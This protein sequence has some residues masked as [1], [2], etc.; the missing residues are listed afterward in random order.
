MVEGRRKERVLSL[1]LAQEGELANVK[2]CR[3]DRA[4]VT[5]DEFCQEVLSALMQHRMGAAS[6]S[7]S[8]AEDARSTNVRSFVTAL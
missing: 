8:F 5:E 2:F 4:S 7:Q 6:V 1:L 3:G